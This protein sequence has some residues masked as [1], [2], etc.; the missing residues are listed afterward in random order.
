MRPV[1]IVHGGAGNDFDDRVAEFRLGVER[2]TK[3]GWARLMEGGSA[4]DAVE[5]AVRALE[6]DPNFDAGHGSFLNAGGEVEMDAM[7]MEGLRLGYGAVAG[8]Q[9]VSNPVSVARLV[10]ERSQHSFLVGAGA[11]RFAREMGVP[12][13]PMEEL[14]A[15][16]S[17][18]LLRPE[19]RVFSQGRAGDTVGAIAMDG[20][21]LLAVAAS[22]GGTAGKMPGRVGDSPIIGC[23]AYADNESGA[24]AATGNGEALMKVLISKSACDFM[25]GG[26]SAQGAVEEALLLLERRFGPSQGGMILMSPT[27]EVGSAFNTNHMVRACICAG[28]EMWIKD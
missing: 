22:T 7:V 18:K 3:A 10:M 17:T 26:M 4:V 28:A 21:G 27:G 1:L 20:A 11:E 5:A 9:R 12:V 13:C 6:D 24:A 19:D 15:R 23:G 16:S 14:V 2:A 25:R 8:I